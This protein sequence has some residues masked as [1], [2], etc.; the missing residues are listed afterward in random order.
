[1]SV[2]FF[3]DNLDNKYRC[4]YS[5]TKDGISVKVQYDIYDEIEPVNGVKAIGINTEFSDRDI[6]IIDRN[7]KNNYLLKNAYFN[8]SCSVYG[9]PDGG[10]IT[11]FFASTYFSHEKLDRLLELREVPKISEIKLFSKSINQLIGNPSIVQKKIENDLYTIQLN[12]EPSK[13]IVNIGHNNIKTIYISEDWKM[14]SS[15]SK[16]DIEFLGHIGIT[17]TRRVDYREIHLFI[18]EMILFLQLYLPGK[19]IFDKILVKV[20][21]I[22]YR[23]YTP[24]VFEPIEKRRAER[25]VNCKLPDFL[26]TCYDKIPYRKG[27]ADV[28]NIPYIVLKKYR[29]IEDNFL[30]YY[31]FIECFYKRKNIPG[32]KHA[33]IKYALEK[34]YD[35]NGWTTERIEKESTEIVALRNHYVHSG[36]YI[37]NNC[38]RIR[39]GKKK[40]P[41]DYTVTDAD[42]TWIYNKTRLLHDVVIGIIFVEMLGYEEYRYP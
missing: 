6:I 27:S 28:R 17:L 21:D 10:T 25:S 1:M 32:I 18:N 30:M 20:G 9:S 31:R 22:F 12:R 2:C 42:V 40:D 11:S 13:Q 14:D 4:E 5:L 29:G 7:E 24:A 38:L 36:Y 3:D 23:Y 15:A 33:F 35:Q 41:K 16:I 39:H 8:G 37:K 19:I 34:H 26:Q